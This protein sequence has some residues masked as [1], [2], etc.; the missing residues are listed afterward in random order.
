MDSLGSSSSIYGNIVLLTYASLGNLPK[1]RIIYGISLILHYNILFINV[2]FFILGEEIEG[3][4]YFFLHVLLHFKFF[5]NRSIWIPHHYYYK[6]II[7][8]FTTAF[9]FSKLS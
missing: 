7:N 4:L 6:S 3:F 5:L 9:A 2:A 1:K 8:P